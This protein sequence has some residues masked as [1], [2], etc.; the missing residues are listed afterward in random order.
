M[1]KAFAEQYHCLEQAFVLFGNHHGHYNALIDMRPA[2]LICYVY[3]FR[4]LVTACIV[5]RNSY[6]TVRT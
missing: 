2:T 3:P 1:I 5:V 4:F 6:G